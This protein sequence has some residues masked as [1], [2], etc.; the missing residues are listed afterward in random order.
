M[1]VMCAI[2]QC[3]NA[4]FPLQP[5]IKDQLNIIYSDD[6]VNQFVLNLKKLKKDFIL[7]RFDIRCMNNNIMMIVIPGR[8]MTSPLHYYSYAHFHQCKLNQD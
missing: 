6:F 2:E 7:M 8:T 4:L 1:W 3:V 5:M